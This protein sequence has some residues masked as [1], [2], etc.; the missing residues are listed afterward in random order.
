MSIR[1][2]AAQPPTPDPIPVQLHVALQHEGPVIPLT[3]HDRA[4]RLLQATGLRGTPPVPPAAA[5]PRT[6]HFGD[7]HGNA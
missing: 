3:T 6:A 7:S 5:T 1:R 2:I 4:V